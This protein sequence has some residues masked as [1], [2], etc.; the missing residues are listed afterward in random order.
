MGI[1]RIV[2]FA[3]ICLITALLAAQPDRID[4]PGT[5]LKDPNP[6]RV[7]AEQFARVQEQQRQSDLQ[8]AAK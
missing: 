5:A 6:M 8:F 3:V 4:E 2:L 7:N 1:F